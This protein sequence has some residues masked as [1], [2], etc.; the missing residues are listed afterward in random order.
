MQKWRYRSLLAK[1]I[2]VN[3][4]ADPTKPYWINEL[5]S[6]GQ[7]G[8]EAVGFAVVG[9]HVIVLLKRPET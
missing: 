8:W 2:D 7:Q 6:L 5:D 3:V 9:E 4:L 1:N